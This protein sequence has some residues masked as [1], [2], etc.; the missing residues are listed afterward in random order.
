MQVIQRYSLHPYRLNSA[1]HPSIPGEMESGHCK[2][3]PVTW[4]YGSLQLL[5]WNGVILATN[6]EA[7][8]LSHVK[9]KYFFTKSKPD[10]VTMANT[11]RQAHLSEN[12][13]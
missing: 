9:V 2:R 11:E 1:A 6:P 7:L 13:I 5:R 10:Q 12:Q 4:I 3:A 8:L